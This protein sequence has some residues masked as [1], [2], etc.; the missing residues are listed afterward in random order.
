METIYANGVIQDRCDS[1]VSLTNDGYIAKLN[2][3]YYHST[4]KQVQMRKSPLKS[5]GLKNE[6]TRRMTVAC[7]LQDGVSCRLTVGD[8][9]HC[10]ADRENSAFHFYYLYKDKYMPYTVLVVDGRVGRVV[11]RIH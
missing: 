5:F 1:I 11:R 2:G 7:F 4:F 8:V 10:C 9:Y 3:V 6:S